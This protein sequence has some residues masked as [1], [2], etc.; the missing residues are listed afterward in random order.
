MLKILFPDKM[1]ELN[2]DSAW[3]G[4]KDN[5]ES[6]RRNDYWLDFASKAM[7][8]K[9]LFPDRVTELDLNDSAWQGMRDELE[10]YRDNNEWWRFANQAMYLKILA[11]DKVEVTD[12]GLELTM[13][14]PEESFKSEK[15]PRPERKNF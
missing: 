9:I 15:K 6:S 3:Q 8:L 5:L 7:R 12:Q 2:L 13:P 14:S 10:S 11:A 1:V 4:M